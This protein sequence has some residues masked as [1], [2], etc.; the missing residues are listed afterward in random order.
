MC[1]LSF[2]ENFTTKTSFIC[3]FQDFWI[4]KYHISTKNKSINTTEIKDS[5]SLR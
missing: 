1:C 5:V 3:S 2:F 4:Y